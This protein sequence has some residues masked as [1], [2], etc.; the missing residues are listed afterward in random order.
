MEPKNPLVETLP[1]DWKWRA[2][3]EPPIS[4]DREWRTWLAAAQRAEEETLLAYWAKRHA[5]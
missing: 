4:A 1:P 5:G 2:L 3:F